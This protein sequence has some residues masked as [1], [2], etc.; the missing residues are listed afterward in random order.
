MN[1]KRCTSF[2]AFICYVATMD[3]GNNAL[4]TKWISTRWHGYHLSLN[5]AIDGTYLMMIMS[6]G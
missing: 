6:M 1:K 5:N 2:T 3:I 4:C